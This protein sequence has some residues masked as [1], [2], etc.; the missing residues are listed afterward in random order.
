MNE[1]CKVLIVDDELLIRQGIK[2]YIQWEQE[3]FQII[4]EAANG[5]EAL[6]VIESTKP[7]I[8]ITDIVMP[9][10]DGEE[11]TKII[12]SKYPDIEVIVLSSFSEFDYVRSTFQQGVNDYILKP[13]LEG[14]EL[15][16]ALRSSADK[17][18]SVQLIRS[19]SNETTL[20]RAMLD[21]W[22]SG[23]DIEVN[24]H[25]VQ[26]T[27]PYSRFLIIG[28]DLKNS[29]ERRSYWTEIILSHIQNDIPQSIVYPLQSERSYLSFLLNLNE[30][31]FHAAF[32]CIE[33]LADSHSQFVWAVS[34]PFSNIKTVKRVYDGSFLT[35][36]H[37]SFYF[38]E[39]SFFN[40]VS[41]PPVQP[42]TRPFNLTVFTELFK[43]EQFDEAI[44]YL[45]AHV[46]DLSNDYTKSAIEFKRFL[47]NVIFNI[48]LL[49]GDMEYDHSKISNEKYRYF[50]AI[51]GASQASEA[52]T[53]LNIFLD[54]AMKIIGHTP[55]VDPSIKKILD[56]IEKNYAEQL[57]LTELANHF[58][59]NP[60]YL[61]TYFS[62][63]N[64]EG[65]SEYV[66]RIR[67]EKSVELLRNRNV[68]ISE[69]SGKVG[70]SDHSYFCKV[71]K[72]LKGMS[73]S[74]YRKQF[75]V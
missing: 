17:I 6:D 23:Y 47:S 7:H 36:M 64:D 48:T 37:Y 9:I 4:G 53:Q 52:V 11:L 66:T 40:H 46:T 28:P 63:H 54:E 49:L 60:S 74:S 65:F 68:S 72:R 51:D 2:H 35:M 50:A 3:G 57:T 71:F 20:I 5:K 14:T 16:K 62:T 15:L 19:S 42:I 31:Q 38:P 33:L 13:K 59:F 73:P 75:F 56:Y 67:I 30:E 18:P 26:Q 41:L 58:H 22:M 8:V 32:H 21:K 10:M 24:N 43:R 34:E 27:F 70:Y 44:Q 25:T 29:G 69:I 55:T 61:S 39:Q 12:K 45:Q 1:L